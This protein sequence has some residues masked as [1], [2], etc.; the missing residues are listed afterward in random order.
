MEL[1]M[2]ESPMQIQDIKSSPHLLARTATGACILVAFLDWWCDSKLPG[3]LVQEPSDI[4]GSSDI[5]G[6]LLY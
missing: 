4:L 3:G 1:L 2:A 6:G 5:L